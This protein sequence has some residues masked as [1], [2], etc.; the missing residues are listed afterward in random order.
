MLSYVRGEA[1]HDCVADDS[2]IRVKGHETGSMPQP[3]TTL[4]LP[5]RTYASLHQLSPSA[6]HIT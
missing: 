6:R 2:S 5:L 3:R 4:P 1:R